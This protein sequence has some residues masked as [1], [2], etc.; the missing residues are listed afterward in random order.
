[1]GRH[2]VSP[3]VIEVTIYPAWSAAA[4]GINSG[5][6]GKSFP[7][8]RDGPGLPCYSLL[9]IELWMNLVC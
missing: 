7:D 9:V 5:R 6:P 4:T 2:Y 8:Q 3:R 1:M